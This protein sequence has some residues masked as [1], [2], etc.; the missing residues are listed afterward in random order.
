MR[1]LSGVQSSGR[2]HIGNYYGAIRQFIQLQSEGEALYFI[3]NLHALTTVREPAKAEEFTREAALAYLSL[4]LD[5]SRAILFRQSDVREVLELY[6]I[7]GTVVPHANLER[8]HSYK[9]KTAK[10]ISPDFGLFAYP[11]LMAAD[12]LLY[13][14]D[15][16]PVGKDQVQHIEFARDWAVKFNLTYVPG[17][18]PADP[19]G[20][21]KGHAPGILKL[22][23]ARLQ[24]STATVMG[25]DGQ[26]MSKSYGNT[27]D[28]FGDEKEIKKRFMSIKSDSTPVEAPKPTE[29]S[30]LYD[31]MKVM[32]PPAEFA[33]ADATW[34]AGG[35]GYGEYKKLLLEAFHATFGPARQRR[36]ELLRDPGELERLLQDGARRAR[37]KAAPLMDQVRRA[38]GIS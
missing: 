38:V 20:K 31:L 37:E 27:I 17:Y 32:L 21:Q 8:A 2:L 18:D 29:G 11:V 16:V 4:G 35:K 24:E 5:P 36:E 7:L 33:A 19:E 30:A 15:V 34:R 22:P 13:S 10:G 25:V 3:A 23:E 12:I 14:A 9:D 1:I 6:W 28:I 26:K